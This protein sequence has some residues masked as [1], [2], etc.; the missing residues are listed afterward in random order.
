MF[1]VKN[2]MD[3]V[4]I[5][6]GIFTENLFGNPVFLAYKFVRNLGVFPENY[7]VIP[8]LRLTIS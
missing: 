1:S 7:A 6:Y 2:V 4:K 5:R 8:F 3:F